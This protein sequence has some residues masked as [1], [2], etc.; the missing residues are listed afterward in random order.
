MRRRLLSA[1]AALALVASMTVAGATTALAAPYCGI[2][3]GSQAK[4]QLIP[5]YGFVVG[6]RGGQQDCF[7]R[8]VFDIASPGAGGYFVNYVDEVTTDGSGEVVPVRG[9]AKLQVVARNRSWGDD[10][11]LTLHP[12]SWTELVDVTGWRTFRQ[13]TWAG[14][15]EGDTTVGLGVRARLPFRAFTITDPGG[16]GRLVVDVAHSW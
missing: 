12:D 3:W 2:T 13:V 9:G 14:T 15:F 10:G 6:I 8:L 5:G 16:R 11:Q 7:D 4:D 1:I